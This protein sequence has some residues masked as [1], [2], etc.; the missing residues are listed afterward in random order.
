V[1]VPPANTVDDPDEVVR[2]LRST[3]AGHLVSSA[4]D[5]SLDATLVPFV[6]DDAMSAIRLHLARANPHWRSLD[7]SA[8]LLIVPVTD[9]YVSPSW[10]P[11]K[12]DDPRVVPTWNYEVVHVHARARVHDEAAF[13]EGVVRDLTD[14]HEQARV[15]RDDRAPAWSVD[16]APD[17]FVA[18]Q[19]RAIVG[20][21]LL[22]ERIEA[23]RKLGQN[24]STADRLG[25]ADGL[26]RA[27]GVHGNPLAAAMRST[28]E[29]GD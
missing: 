15:G 26:D 8:A 21:E 25:V 1:Y 3:G 14:V 16:D 20:V 5:G 27:S 29:P 13:V 28:A 22:I 7:G 6:V 12:A 17:D 23:K 19:L 4:G 24:R 9:G 11:S 18:R 2:L 10:Y